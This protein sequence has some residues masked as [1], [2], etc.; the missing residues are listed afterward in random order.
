MLNYLLRHMRRL[1]RSAS[2]AFIVGAVAAPV[3]SPELTFVSAVHADDDDGGDD[4]DDGNDG[5]ARSGRSG[6]DG[7]KRLRGPQNLMDYLDNRRSV[8][9]PQARPTAKRQQAAAPVYEARRLIA[10]GLSDD[11]I[12]KLQERGFSV[13]DK[14]EMRLTGTQLIRLQIPP[15]MT[16]NTA[17]QQVSELAPEAMVDFNHYYRPEQADPQSESQPD[18]AACNGTDCTL[19]RHLIG[20]KQPEAGAALCTALPKIGLIDTAINPDHESLKQARIEIIRLSDAEL[21]QSGT[22]HGTAVA[23]L[24]VG[25]ETGRAP[26]LLPQAELIAV[27]AFHGAK[28]DSNRATTFDLIRAVDLLAEK[29]VPLINMSLSGPHNQLLEKAIEAA[30]QRKIILVAAAGNE[31]PHAKPVYPAAYANVIAVTA[32][33]RDGKP[34]RRAVRGAHI[35]LAAPGV[36]VWTAASV[37][38]ARQ[39]TGT[40]FAAPFVTAAAARLKAEKPDLDNQQIA[41]ELAGK[42]KDLGKP[43]HDPVFG[44]GLINA[45]ALC[46][47]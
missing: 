19:M 22:Q 1:L 47:S 32:V 35:D 18:A 23:A 14:S 20:W 21:P 39:K 4:G 10:L 12:T 26:G 43:G 28:G 34:Y 5:G 9:A 44:W 11:H 31:G 41:E 15:R 13:E 16:L 42:A 6:S 29:Q 30:A 46:A 45:Q 3:L 27:D 8:R 40:S 25:S 17:R 36:G 37:S 2:L 33:D 7:G 24:L 38:G